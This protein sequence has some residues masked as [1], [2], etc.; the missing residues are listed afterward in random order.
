MMACPRLG[1]RDSQP[2]SQVHNL[3]RAARAR[4][5]VSLF[6][7]A[8]KAGREVGRE[9]NREF[10][11]LSQVTDVEAQVRLGALAVE[12]LPLKFRTSSTFEPLKPLSKVSDEIAEQ[13]VL[14]SVLLRYAKQRGMRR[15]LHNVRGEDAE[16]GERSRIC[17]DNHLLKT[18]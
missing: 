2:H 17:R 11:G 14:L 7:F 3:D 18:E 12:A 6:V 8:M 13:G 10:V 1:C 15:V 16:G 9:R 4:I 5:A